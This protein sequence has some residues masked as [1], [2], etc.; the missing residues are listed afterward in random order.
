MRLC[1][2]RPSF[3]RLLS[4]PRER[5]QPWDQSLGVVPCLRGPTGPGSQQDGEAGAGPDHAVWKQA[6]RP[7]SKLRSLLPLDFLSRR[8]G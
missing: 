6:P 1:R 7:G 2:E 8:A 5:V 3:V 4:A